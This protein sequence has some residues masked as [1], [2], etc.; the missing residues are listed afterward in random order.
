[1]KKTIL[2]MVL[3]FISTIANTQDIVE[4]KRSKQD[5]FI[6][7]SFK[8]NRFISDEKMERFIGRVQNSYP[9]VDKIEYEIQDNLFSIFLNIEEI[10]EDFLVRLLTHFHIYNY[11]IIDN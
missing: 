9:Q 3:I 4:L 1:M 5:S 6:V 10:D 11:F 7:L 8:S 2:F